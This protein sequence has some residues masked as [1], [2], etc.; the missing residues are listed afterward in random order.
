MDRRFLCTVLAVLAVTVG[1]AALVNRT[2]PPSDKPLY[3]TVSG[4]EREDAP[5]AGS[6][7]AAEPAPEYEYII[8]EHQG[9]V[10][11]FSTADDSEPQL[12]LETLVKFLPDYDRQ[13]LSE[14]VP[15]RDSRELFSRIEDY[16]S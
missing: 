3:A 5:P 13:Q 2:E 11:V 9:R 14:G 1:T 6:E 4:V 16:I 15:V 8:R 12:V 7:Q 10:A